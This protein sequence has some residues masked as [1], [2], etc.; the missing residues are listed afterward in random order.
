MYHEV[1]DDSELPLLARKT[2]RGYIV[3]RAAFERQMRLLAGAGFH[4]VSLAALTAWANESGTLPA[5]PIVITFDDGYEG[6][7]RHAWP[8]LQQHDFT[9]TFFVV[10]NKIGDSRMMTWSQLAE[11]HASGMAI[12][13]HTANH[14]LLSTLDEPRTRAELALSK[15]TIED[16]LGA[17]VQFLSLPNGD[18]NAHYVAVARELGYLGGCCSRFGFNDRTTDRYFWRRIAV[19]EGMPIGRFENLVTQHPRTVARLR[20]V[21]A[22]KAAVTALLGKKNYDRLYNFVFGVEQQD[23]SKLTRDVEL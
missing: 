5:R 11:M 12:E 14:P 21:A 18:S 13:S 19:K 4:T 16:R 23:K 6:N 9:A 10:S 8:I 1:A 3:T 2:Q 20:A 7:Y 22:A 15:S 17:A